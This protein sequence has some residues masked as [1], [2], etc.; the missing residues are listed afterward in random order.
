MLNTDLAYLNMNDSLARSIKA[1]VEHYQGST[2]LGTY[3]YNDNL[4][5]IHVDRTATSG[6]FFGFG[7]PQTLTLKLTDKDNSIT[8]TKGDTFKIYFS[9]NDSEYLRVGPQFTADDIKR[10]EKTN[11][12]TTIALD[13][14]SKLA[15]RNSLGVYT[16][17]KVSAQ[18]VFERAAAQL[19]LTL[20]FVNF[21][22]TAWDKVYKYKLNYTASE[23]LKGL[24][25][26][27][28]EEMQVIYYVEAEYLCI[29]PLDVAGDSDYTISKQNYYELTTKDAV[30]LTGIT[31]VNELGDT[32]ASGTADCRQVAKDNAFWSSNII[33]NV[34]GNTVLLQTVLDEAFARISDLT[35]VPYTCS[36]R[37]N[38]A[39][40]LGDKIAI[41]SKQGTPITTYLLNDSYEYNGGFKQ[42]CSWEYEQVK[43]ESTKP[44][45][46]SEKISTT[47][48]KVDKAAQEIELLVTSVDDNSEAISQLQLNE[49]GIRAEVTDIDKSIWESIDGVQKEI[50]EL[51]NKVETV[52]TPTEVELK[53]SE[54]L[55]SGVDSVTTTTGFKFDNEGLHISK[56]TS[57]MES[58]L[59]E[60]GLTVT[61]GSTNMLVATS[62]GVEARN[63]N[64]KEYLKVENI[65]F[66][67]YNGRMGCFWVGG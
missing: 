17:S 66:E 48:A 55:A 1:K 25:D 42:T 33:E 63:L 62:D 54:T 8:V 41:E 3:N 58:L 19:D 20:K 56:S 37:G 30:T 40:E 46:V 22:S 11:G 49:G 6:K 21:T 67:K 10:D 31:H 18:T 9:A 34:N 7:I 38:F 64:A 26:A 39:L 13:P 59:D 57:E 52:I 14:I 24:L 43:T 29:R 23:P 12:I 15:E 45:T 44:V 2:L 35:I 36:W 60:T 27:A 32:T 16:S 51:M 28:A 4:Q 47:S 5:N 50:V 53:I 61:R 65:R